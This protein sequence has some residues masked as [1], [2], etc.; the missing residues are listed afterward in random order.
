MCVLN[1]PDVLQNIILIL[2]LMVTLSIILYV[3]EFNQYENDTM[4]LQKEVQCIQDSNLLLK[5]KNLC[6]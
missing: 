3:F 5:L 6:M 2:L 4:N 1:L